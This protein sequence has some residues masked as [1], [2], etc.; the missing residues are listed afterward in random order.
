VLADLKA[1]NDA[2]D[3]TILQED[4]E[5]LDDEV[6]EERGRELAIRVQNELGTEGWE[7]L[8]YLG[9][10]VHRVHP[11]GSWPAETWEQDL[12]GYAPLAPRIL[13]EEE[14]RI[15]EGLCEDQQQTGVDG[16]TSA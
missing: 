12:L 8:Y 7:G 11:Q 4:E 3:Y 1:W 16:P 2:H 13:A 15:L 14:A 9:G 6:L 10:R 5:I